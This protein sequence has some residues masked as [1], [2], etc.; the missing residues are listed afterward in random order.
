MHAARAFPAKLAMWDAEH[1]DPK[2]CSGHWLAQHGYLKRLP[3]GAT[4][5]GLALSHHGT[6]TISKADEE[7]VRQHGL[8]VLDCSWTKAE[9]ISSAKLKAKEHVLLPFLVAAN[10]INYGKPF[11]LNDAEALAAALYIVGMQ[12]EA[13]QLLQSFRYGPEFF[14]I[15]HHV[16]EGYAACADGQAVVQFQ[17]KYLKESLEAIQAKKAGADAAD[18]Y[19]GLPE[20]SEESSDAE[21]EDDVAKVEGEVEG[22]EM[23]KLKQ[24]VEQAAEKLAEMNVVGGESAGDAK[25]CC[26]SETAAKAEGDG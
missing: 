11:K 7:V 16:L 24:K 1:C 17:E 10:P 26:G 3:V 13:K 25:E 19:Y 21:A 23:G 4:F 20:Y 18:P 2:H 15:N 12:E 22:G 8:I 14:K 6:R 9:E 5:R